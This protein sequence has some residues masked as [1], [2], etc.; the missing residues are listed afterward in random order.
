MY[1]IT[2]KGFVRRN[3]LSCWDTDCVGPVDSET[4]V[5][6]VPYGLHGE[7]VCLADGLLAVVELPSHYYDFDPE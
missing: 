3:F 6:F 5:R 4:A 7:W 2:P 1:R